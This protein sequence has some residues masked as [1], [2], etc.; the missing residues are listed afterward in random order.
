ML[1]REVA[2]S[3][4]SL[5]GGRVLEKLHGHLDPL[6]GPAGVQALLIRS[7]L[8][9]AVEFPFLNPTVV[10]SAAS[11]RE[12]LQALEPGVAREST[13]ALFGNFFALI[14][15]FIGERLTTQVLLSAWPTVAERDTSK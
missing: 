3:D 1:A 10:S 14:N 12:C 11:M 7:T 13:V 5:A 9:A 6:I 8:L 4:E 15:T 2:A